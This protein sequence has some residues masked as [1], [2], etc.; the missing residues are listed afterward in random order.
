[1]SELDKE[2][3][4]LEQLR[5]QTI[6]S[7]FL[8]EFLD[9]KCI[10]F[11]E[12]HDLSILLEEKEIQTICSRGYY[13]PVKH[14]KVF[15]ECLHQLQLDHPELIIPEGK[16]ERNLIALTSQ[17]HLTPEDVIKIKS[18]LRYGFT[19]KDYQEKVETTENVVGAL[20]LSIY[21]S[22]KKAFTIDSYMW[23]DCA[24]KF[25]GLIPY[26]SFFSYFE[27][28]ATPAIFD[29]STDVL[30]I[31]ARSPIHKLRFIE[32]KPL[33]DRNLIKGISYFIERSTSLQS[34]TIDVSFGNG[35][36]D[37]EIISCLSLGLQKNLSLRR[38]DVSYIKLD[39]S[40][41]EVVSG[42]N[43]VTSHGWTLF[44]DSI[45]QSNIEHLVIGESIIPTTAATQLLTLMKERPSLIVDVKY[46]NINKLLLNEIEELNKLRS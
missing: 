15:F 2:L 17:G 1:M 36:L 6:F 38:L 33:H 12:P 18:Y 26:D 45:T 11:Y 31:L 20:S 34:I 4:Q 41:N 40:T 43:K 44:I 13:V 16:L 9:D 22:D 23:F 42:C 24:R 10:R 8:G 27:S 46:N 32:F 3:Q 21:Y 37:G 7:F 14:A 5:Q 39:D 28:I 29:S 35:F 25:E 19:I 30:D